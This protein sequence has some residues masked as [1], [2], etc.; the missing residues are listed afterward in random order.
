LIRLG[1][2]L[3]IECSAKQKTENDPEGKLIEDDPEKDAYQK[4]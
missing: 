1:S 2:L 3:M 4:T